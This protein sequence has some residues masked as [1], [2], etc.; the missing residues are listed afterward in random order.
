MCNNLATVLLLYGIHA[1]LGFLCRNILKTQYKQSASV[2]SLITGTVG[3]VFSAFGILLSGL[4]IS[5][6]KPKARYFGRV[7][8]DGLA[9]Y[10]GRRGWSL[11]RSL[12]VPPTTM[13]ITVQ[14]DG[15]LKTLLRVTNNVIAITVTY[16][17]CLLRNMGKPLFQLVTLDVAI[18]KMQANGSKMYTECSCIKPKF[19]RLHFCLQ[20]NN[21]TY[22]TEDPLETPRTWWVSSF[23]HRGYREPVL[24]IVCINFTSFWLW[25]VCSSSVE[26]LEGRRT[27]LVSG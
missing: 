27:F 15:A 18:Y 1:L 26:Q 17:S 25:F 16:T 11:T 5:K 14:P 20:N 13:Q 19:A 2:S 21:F 23:R 4:I 9:L 24:W 12:A 3:L 8:R 7:E 22:T 6:Y 10:I